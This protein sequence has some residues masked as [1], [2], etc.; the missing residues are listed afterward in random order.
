[1]IQTIG[2]GLVLNAIVQA[3]FRNVQADFD[4]ARFVLVDTDG[5]INRLSVSTER[6]WNAPPPKPVEQDKLL[7]YYAMLESMPTVLAGVGKRLI[8]EAN[9]V[10]TLHEPGSRLDGAIATLSRT[11]Y[12]QVMN[13]LEVFR[14]NVLLYREDGRVH[15]GVPQALPVHAGRSAY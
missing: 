4:F 8:E 5:G 9:C 3:G 2:P 6:V 7:A 15:G 14:V 11:D 13:R 10:V 12:L 1:M